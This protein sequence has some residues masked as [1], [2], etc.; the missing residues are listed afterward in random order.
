MNM[1]GKPRRQTKRYKINFAIQIKI[2]N[3]ISNVLRKQRILIPADTRTRMKLR[4]NFHIM[5]KTH[6]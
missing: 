4:H 3:E 6:K 5:E 1:A 2:I